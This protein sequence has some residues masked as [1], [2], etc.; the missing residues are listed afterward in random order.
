[1]PEGP[2]PMETRASEGQPSGGGEQHPKN[3]VLL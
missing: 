3:L 2:L 1:M